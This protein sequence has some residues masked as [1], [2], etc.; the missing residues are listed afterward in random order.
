MNIR[1][2]DISTGQQIFC[3]YFAELEHVW[4]P[5]SQVC[6]EW[7]SCSPDDVHAGQDEDGTDTV[8]VCGK[9]VASYEIIF[10]RAALRRM[11]DAA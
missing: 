1:I 10:P 11:E 9:A 7:F 5:V 4:E 8:E 2:T 3:G 6:A